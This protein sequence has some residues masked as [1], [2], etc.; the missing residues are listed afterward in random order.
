METKN[1]ERSAI[2][3]PRPGDMVTIGRF[4]RVVTGR[5]GGVVFYAIKTAEPRTCSINDWRR[6]C[7]IVYQ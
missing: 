2:D 4:T 6:W 3:D 5:D 7:Q 1:D